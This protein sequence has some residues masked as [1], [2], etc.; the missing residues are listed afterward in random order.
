IMIAFALSSQMPANFFWCCS[1]IFIVLWLPLSSRSLK[2]SLL[3]AP[4]QRDSAEL[5]RFV[6]VFGL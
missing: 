6:E 5:A 3:Y 4:P 1:F 2:G